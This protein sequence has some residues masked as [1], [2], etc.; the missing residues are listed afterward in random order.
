MMI[1]EKNNE[2]R[3]QTLFQ[4][5]HHQTTSTVS[6]VKRSE[7]FIAFRNDEPRDAFI[8]SHKLMIK[9]GLIAPV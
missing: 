9:G 2:E 7:M 4:S 6:L 5:H 1:S 3:S 8:A